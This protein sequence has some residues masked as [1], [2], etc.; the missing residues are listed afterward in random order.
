MMPSLNLEH[1][2][3]G[4]TNFRSWKTNIILALEEIDLHNHVNEVILEP[5]RAKEKVKYKNNKRNTKRILIDLIKDH[6]IPHVVELKTTKE[7]YD[8]FVGL[9]ESN[10]TSKKLRLR[11]QL[12]S[13]IMT[14]SYFVVSYHMTSS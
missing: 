11:H 7:L 4:A 1:K 13:V 3:D 6:L 10:N 14:R 9:Y 2:L 8:A 5:K 12:C